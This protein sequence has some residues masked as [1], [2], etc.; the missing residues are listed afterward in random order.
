MYKYYVLFKKSITNIWELKENI[1]IPGVKDKRA[2]GGRD[3]KNHGGASQQPAEKI[4]VANKLGSIYFLELASELEVN[5]LTF[6]SDKSLKAPFYCCS[7]SYSGRLT[8]QTGPCNL[9]GQIHLTFWKDAYISIL[10]FW[11]S[12]QVQVYLAHKLAPAIFISAVIFSL[13]I[14]LSIKDL[15]RDFPFNISISLWILV[16]RY[17]I[18]MIHFDILFS[19]G[20]DKV[21]DIYVK[22]RA[23]GFRW[24]F[25]LAKVKQAGN[26][27]CWSKE[28]WKSNIITL[29]IGQ[30][31][32][33]LA[34]WSQ[35]RVSINSRTFSNW[36]ES[37]SR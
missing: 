33:N 10:T 13:D 34:K 32:L 14:F 26:G 4:L 5:L 30:L 19:P 24:K 7:S 29:R 23:G 22:W 15:V 3:I 11:I 27:D 2:K 17:K 37:Q 9:Y 16:W 6:P 31:Y 20:T 36:Q 28:L 25:Q 8:G 35:M 18:T 1:K 12:V 21:L